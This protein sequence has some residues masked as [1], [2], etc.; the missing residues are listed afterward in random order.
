MNVLF[1]VLKLRRSI[2]ICWQDNKRTLQQDPEQFYKYEDD[3]KRKKEDD[4]CNS[5]TEDDRKITDS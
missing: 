2:Q 1:K 4:I 5:E 3:I